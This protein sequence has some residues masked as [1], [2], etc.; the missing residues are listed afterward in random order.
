MG[1]RLFLLGLEGRSYGKSYTVRTAAVLRPQ[2]ASVKF[3]SRQDQL[4]FIQRCACDVHSFTYSPKCQRK[5][6]L[7]VLH[8][9]TGLHSLVTTRYMPG[10]ADDVYYLRC[11]AIGCSRGTSFSFSSG[12]NAQA[13][14]GSSV[15]V[16]CG[17]RMQ[18]CGRRSMRASRGDTL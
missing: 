17:P 16:C 5:E 2:S 4:S 7:Q 8:S 11:R 18:T 6:S 10:N 9:A 1:L 3:G 13:L 12:M 15:T 14:Y